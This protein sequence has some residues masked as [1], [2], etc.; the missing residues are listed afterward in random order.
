MSTGADQL[1]RAEPS[2]V[3]A[4]LAAIEEKLDAVLRFCDVVAAAAA[5]LMGGKGKVWMA[6]LAK[7][8]GG[9]T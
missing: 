5:P 2:E 1:E 6:L 4:R 8:R 9:G 7:S 3:D